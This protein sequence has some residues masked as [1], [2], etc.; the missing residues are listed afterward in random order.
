MQTYFYYL[1]CLVKQYMIF[2]C[3]MPPPR[4]TLVKPKT[5]F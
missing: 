5:W 4:L 3:L 1:V 2:S